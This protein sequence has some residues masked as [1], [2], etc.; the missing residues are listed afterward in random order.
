M[1]AQSTFP[2]SAGTGHRTLLVA[3]LAGPILFL[4]A[5]LSG[6]A[7]GRTAGS[8]AGSGMAL[9]PLGWVMSVI[10]LLAGGCIVAFAIG[11]WRALVPASRIGTALLVIAGIAVMASGLLVTDADGAPETFHGQAHNLLFLVVMVAL[12][13]SFPFNG[14]K[15]RR[16]GLRGA[17]AHAIASTAALPV[18]VGFFVTVASSPGDPFYAIGSFVEFTLVAVAFGWIAVNSFRLL[19]LRP[20]LG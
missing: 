15:L 3:G 19:R 13:V 17:L 1:S 2:S 6:L 9:G 20:A 11:Q 12:A 8:S 18:V 7:S 5:M 14:L 16:A 10:F 4:G